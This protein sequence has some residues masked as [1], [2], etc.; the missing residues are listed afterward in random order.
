MCAAFLGACGPFG[1]LGKVSRD[2][3]HA[4]AEAKAV[5][6]QELAPYEYWSAVTYLEQARVMMGYSEYERAFDYGGRAQQLADEAKRKVHQ[7]EGARGRGDAG[8]SP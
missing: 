2:A 7:H 5:G 8:V 3:S 4:V 1:Y 6:A